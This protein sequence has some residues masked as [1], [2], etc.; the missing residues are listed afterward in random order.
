MLLGVPNGLPRRTASPF[1]FRP[2][3]GE[4]GACSCQFLSFGKELVGARQVIGTK[5]ADGQNSPGT[6]LTASPHTC[7]PSTSWHQDLHRQLCLIFT[8]RHANPPQLWL[9]FHFQLR[10]ALGQGERGSNCMRRGAVL[11]LR[12]PIVCE[13][14]TGCIFEQSSANISFAD[15]R[16]RCAGGLSCRRQKL[17]R[18]A[19]SLASR[20]VDAR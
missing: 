7:P 19:R 20:A 3:S 18:R 14:S 15:H 13:P 9:K 11:G 8:A 17:P 6:W 5:D 12:P 4:P 16:I 10:R 1:L 2:S